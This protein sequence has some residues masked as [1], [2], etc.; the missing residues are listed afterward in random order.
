MPCSPELDLLIQCARLE[1]GAAQQERIESLVDQKLNWARV[2]Q[3][4]EFHRLTPLLDLHLRSGGWLSDEVKENLSAKTMGALA[5]NMRI[6]AELHKLQRQ[7][8]AA[9]VPYL[10]IKGPVTAY[11]TYGHLGLRPFLDLDVLVKRCD[12]DKT[13]SRLQSLGFAPQ[14]PLKPTQH[15]IYC[16]HYT[17]ICM[18]RGEPAFILDLHWEL[19]EP[20]YTFSI[21]PE[22]GW[23]SRTRV[24]IDGQEIFTLNDDDWLLFAC[25]H[26]SKHAWSRISWLVDIAEHVRKHPT[27]NF[28]YLFGRPEAKKSRVR[29]L[30]TLA[31]VSRVLAAEIP[32]R[33]SRQFDSDRRVSAIVRDVA[34]R[35]EQAATPRLALHRDPHYLA[36]ESWS[37]RLN[38]FRM[39]LFRATPIELGLV[40]LPRYLRPAYYFIRPIRLLY[41]YV[42]GATRS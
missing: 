41:R 8:S 4:A 20:G 29:L 40:P 3:L 19:V 27:T 13:L 21:D 38:Y 26:A 14:F 33:I 15:K 35:W 16:D 39:H 30:T 12:L 25:L 11:E 2:L 1:L 22:T 37:D 32:E 42:T 18:W 6:V 24:K 31:L 34:T 10:V 36:F 9:E 7:L 17:E 5:T 23:K 28:D